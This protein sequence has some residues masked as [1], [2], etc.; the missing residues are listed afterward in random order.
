MKSWNDFCSF[1]NRFEWFFYFFLFLFLSSTTRRTNLLFRLHCVFCAHKN[2]LGSHIF[3]KGGGRGN[4]HNKEPWKNCEIK[5]TV[6]EILTSLNAIS[7]SF[8]AFK[9]VQCEKSEAALIPFLKAL[10]KHTAQKKWKNETRRKTWSN[11]YQ[12]SIKHFE[13]V[14]SIFLPFFFSPSQLYD[15]FLDNFSDFKCLD[16]ANALQPHILFQFYLFFSFL[17]FFFSFLTSKFECFLDEMEMDDDMSFWRG[18]DLVA[19]WSIYFT[20]FSVWDAWQVILILFWVWTQV[21]S[22]IWFDVFEWSFNWKF[23][24]FFKKFK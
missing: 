4:E 2:H 12:L 24:N 11:P 10:K 23:E 17:N 14:I 18:D 16:N 20:V 8:K 6:E 19:A 9:I 21:C 3:S 1:I 5:V 22:W 7:M 15:R 13:D